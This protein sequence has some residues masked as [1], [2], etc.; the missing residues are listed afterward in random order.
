MKRLTPQQQRI[1]QLALFIVTFITTTI[2]GA[3]WI[4]GKSV[5][6]E[7]RMSWQEFLD[8]LWFSIPFL[9]I[10]SVHEFG[11]YFTAMY[12]KVKVTLPYY[13]PFWLGFIPFMPSIGT[14]GA[15]IRIKDRYQTRKQYFDIGIAGPLAGFVVAIAVLY[16]GFTHLPDKRFLYDVHPEYAYFG[17]MEPGVDAAQFLKQDTFLL[18]NDFQE[19]LGFLPE[20]WEENDTIKVGGAGLTLGTSLMFELCKEYFVEDKSLLPPASE[21][22]HYPLLFAGFLAL[23]FTALNLVPIGQL[24]GGHILYGLIGHKWF[25]RISPGIYIAF[26]T[27]AG[28]GIVNLGTFSEYSVRGLFDFIWVVLI[29]LYFLNFCLTR[30]FNDRKNRWLVATIIFTFQYMISSLFPGFEGGGSLLLIALLGRFIGV[31]HPK[32]M[33]DKPLSTGRQVL[34]WFSLIVLILCGSLEPLVFG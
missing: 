18:T 5:L 26:L 7:P 22:I 24:D 32:A 29:Y 31:Y 4:H 12:H 27:Y 14:M 20:T 3:E 15:V 10:L 9:L 16:Y 30:V 13:I 21:L 25:N 8:G 19:K 33:L 1:F 2:A 34:G 28:L 11:H 6:Y 23:F 17:L